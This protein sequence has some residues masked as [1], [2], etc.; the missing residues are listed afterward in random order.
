MG[1]RIYL[2]KA[3]ITDRLLF[4]KGRAWRDE[5]LRRKMAEADRSMRDIAPKFMEE[6]DRRIVERMRKWADEQEELAGPQPDPDDRFWPGRGWV[7]PE[8]YDRLERERI[9]REIEGSYWKARKELDDE[10]K[11]EQ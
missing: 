6:S 4:W 2:L 5:R 3:E 1:Y 7:S 9:E 8:E 11:G 10:R